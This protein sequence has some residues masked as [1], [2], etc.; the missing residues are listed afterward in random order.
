MSAS[1][2][3]AKTVVNPS[4]V[5]SASS[6]MADAVSGLASFETTYPNDTDADAASAIMDDADAAAEE[7]ATVLAGK[8]EADI[9]PIAEFDAAEDPQRGDDNLLGDW[10]SE[11]M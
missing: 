2:F 11:P 9:P 10:A 5:A 6:M 3:A 4:M 7:F 1:N 8:L